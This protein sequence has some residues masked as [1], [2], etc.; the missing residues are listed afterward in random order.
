MNIVTIAAKLEWK[1]A[2]DRKTGHLVAVCEPLNLAMA[3]DDE[4]DLQENIQETLQ[5]F[6]SSLVSSGEFDTFLRQHGWTSTPIPSAH[7][8]PPDELEF[9]VPYELI[10]RKRIDGTARAAH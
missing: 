10:T 2:P 7:V 1:A 6:F 4:R 8:V 5:M 9:D 3:G